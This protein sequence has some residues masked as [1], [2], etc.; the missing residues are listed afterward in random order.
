[1]MVLEQSSGSSK[2]R[3]LNENRFQNDHLTLPVKFGR[4]RLLRTNY[5]VS[6][7]FA[8][9]FNLHIQIKLNSL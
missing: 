1:M 7:N 2:D 6:L 9:N 3:N 5:R 8:L 4:V